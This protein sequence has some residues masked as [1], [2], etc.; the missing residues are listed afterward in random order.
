MA[1]E[2]SLGFSDY[3]SAVGRR[4][5]LGLS[6][7]I[8][9][10]VAAIV[11]AVALPS[12]FRSQAMFEMEEAKLANYMP[13]AS[14]A[15]QVMQLDQYVASLAE[16][17]LVDT[18]LGEAVDSLHPYSKLTDDRRKAIAEMRRNIDIKMVKRKVL[19]PLSGREREIISG[20][21]VGYE[22]RDPGTTQKVA[23]W[24]AEAFASANREKGRARAASAAGF[25][26]A[27]AE[28][29]R[30]SIAE[31]EK[32]LADFKSRNVGRLP[33]QAQMNLQL[34]DRTSTDLENVQTQLRGLQRD[35]VYLAQQLAQAQANPQA[36][37]VR[38]LEAEYAHRLTIYD[39]N[40]PDVISLRRQI[41][42]LKSG[43]PVDG[44]TLQAQLES[45]KA[46][47][48]GARQRYSEDH[49]DVKRVLRKVEALEARIAAGEGKN[50]AAPVRRTPVIVQLQTQINA[51]DTQI[52]G[53]EAQAASL[54]AKV[55]GFE[56]R[57]VTS[58]EV[59]RE[60]QEINR[61][62]SGARDKYQQ[63]TNQQ[64]DA[65][66]L[67]SAI[68]GGRGDEFRMV[69][70]PELPRSPAS[71]P[72]VAIVVLGIIAAALFALISIVI[73]ESADPTVRGKHD[74]RRVLGLTPLAVV[75][76]I[77]TS[78][79]VAREKMQVMRFAGAV[80]V[81]GVALF[82]AIRVLI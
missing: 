22:H 40:H 61:D 6:V 2:E 75:P 72:R 17:A 81:A 21:T 48:A 80:A 10:A 12:R 38:E 43:G 31:G 26:A 63:L 56:S 36:D 20:F 52:A 78:Q 67:E 34:M 64:R 14:N 62:L 39:E 54:R 25:F 76:E 1:A 51:T 41:E 46:V 79:A 33:D 55:S 77:R 50:T 68:A 45:E 60:Y 69:Q 49:P 73:A 44:S 9:I 27:E 24:L 29:L 4:R 35:R 30:A 82:A 3:F 23:A 11:V 13:N 8:P 28:R 5:R 15:G 65:E 42:A 74:V 16:S 71:P 18:K 58:P 47:L 32:R 19:D 66:L 59:E 70:A 57:L 7:G 37:N 53:L